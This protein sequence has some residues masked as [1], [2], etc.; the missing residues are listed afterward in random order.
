MMTRHPG[1]LPVGQSKLLPSDAVIAIDGP[2]GSGKSTTAR[3]LAD[4]FGLLYIDT[5]AMYRALTLASLQ[6]NISAADETSLA[7]LLAESSL[8]LQATKGELTVLW[9]GKDVSR[10]IR[11][12]QVEA[13]VSQVAAH[14]LVRREMVT[15]QQAMGRR[16]GVV[17]EGRDIGSVVFPLATAKVYLSASLEARVERRYQQYKQRGRAV[18]RE[19]LTHDLAD[20]D[21]Q[22]SERETSPLSIC[23]DA[24]V[25]DSSNMSLAQ[26]NEACARA[27]YVNPALDQDLDTDLPVALRELPA[28]YRFAYFIMRG[29]SRFFGLKQY[30]NEGKALPRGCIIAINHVSMWDPPFVGSTFHRYPVHTLAKAELFKLWPLGQIFRWVDAIPIKRQGYD[31]S[32]FNG[33]KTILNAGHNLVIFPEG[34][35]R[36]IGHPGPVRKG[37]GIVVQATRAPVLPIFIRGSYGKH[38]G[39][40]LLSPLEINY[41]P[42]MRWH[43]LDALLEKREPKEVSGV[44]GELCEA[45]FRELQTRSYA[46]SPETPF[47]ARLG[48]LQLKKFAIR[49]SQVFGS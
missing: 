43:G 29:V 13:L 2:A 28:R 7:N 36:A 49:Q 25:I 47:E 1:E 12:P 37:L 30:G 20:R 19:A 21:R 14:P 15:R 18:T 41:G 46:R 6:N 24:F 48:Q 17:M 4:R 31:A 39:G 44:I 5:G 42:L 34:T 40:S 3:S 35:R 23:P 22:D 32:A 16:G 27:C 8:E 33:A 10:E 45:A 9:N 26:Q 38:P 11:T